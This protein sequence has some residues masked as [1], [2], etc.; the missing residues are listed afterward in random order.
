MKVFVCDFCEICG[1]LEALLT[2]VLYK[3]E[4][5]HQLCWGL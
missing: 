5:L 3:F 1:L 2:F 4:L